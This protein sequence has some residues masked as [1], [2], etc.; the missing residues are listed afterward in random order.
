M[1]NRGKKF[2]NKNEKNTL[3]DLGFTPTIASGSGWVEKEDGESEFALSQLK[4]TDAESIRIKEQDLLTLAYNADMCRKLGI[5]FIQFLKTNNVYMMINVNDIEQIKDI[6]LGEKPVI[7]EA[8]VRED[9]SMGGRPVIKSSAKGRDKILAEESEKW[10][11][12]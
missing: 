12:K 6:V 10:R 4:T 11:K 5:F 1:S 7:Y 8:Y 3:S 2:Y 9:G